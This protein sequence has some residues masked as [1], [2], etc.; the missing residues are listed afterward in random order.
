[1]HRPLKILSDFDGVW[2]DQGPEADALDRFVAVELA[3]LTGWSLDRVQETLSRFS[4]RMHDAPHHHGWAP[5][6][7]IS[8]YVDEDPLCRPSALCRLVEQSSDP[9]AEALRSAVATGGFDCMASFAERCFRRGTA[10][11]REEHPPCIVDDARSMLEALFE[12]GAEVV[13]VSNSETEKIV[14]WLRSA[15][16]DAGDH[17]EARVRVRGSAAKW[18][19][20]HTD[21]ALEIGGRSIYVDRPRYR[22][23]ILAEDPDVII[24]DVF[25]LDLALPHVMRTQGNPAAP[26]RLVLRRHPHTPRWVL[27]DRAGGAIDDVVD[28]VGELAD[29]VRSLEG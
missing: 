7:R 15:G 1:M 19:L 25:S 8:A 27:D 21:A 11:F 12:A 23:A 4:A 22:D 3:A 6:G 20:G 28:R 26:R 2:T 16:I 9:D 24:G 10:A 18:Q 5:D 17:D 13:V 14:G 29:I